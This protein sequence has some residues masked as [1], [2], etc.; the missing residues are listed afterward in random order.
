MVEISAETTKE[1]EKKIEVLDAPELINYIRDN[2]SDAALG[3]NTRGKIFEKI[4]GVNKKGYSKAIS[5]D[6]L[7]QINSSFRTSNGNDWARSHTSYL[8][9]KY[10]IRRNK[11]HGRVVSVQLDGLNH[12]TTR[13]QRNIPPN[14]KKALTGQ[15]CCVLGIRSSTGM[16]IDHKN[17][18]YDVLTDDPSEYQVMSKPVNDAK[19]QHCKICMETGKRYDAH[20]RGFSIGWTMGDENSPT[21]PG[22]YWYDPKAFNA[23]VA[24]AT[25]AERDAEK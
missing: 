13:G 2:Y 20:E 22:C 5:V 1:I 17:A 21:C 3:P 8:G 24:D 12:N 19:R 9:K 25:L 23:E 14:V 4:C 6:Y 15:P 10:I 11:E 16:E 18:R 7:A